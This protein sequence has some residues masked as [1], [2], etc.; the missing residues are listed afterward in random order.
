MVYMH[1]LEQKYL[2]FKENRTIQMK[3]IV[4]VLLE[5]LNPFATVV[6]W[7]ICRLT[8]CSLLFALF[9]PH[10][11]VCQNCTKIEHM[12]NGLT[13]SKR[14]QD[15]EIKGHCCFDRK[16]FRFNRKTLSNYMT[17]NVK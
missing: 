3:Y 4:L 7:L 6:P 15:A 12:Y 1:V 13:N 11:A 9:S 2:K 8:P 17:E 14:Y 16:K 10:D 5:S